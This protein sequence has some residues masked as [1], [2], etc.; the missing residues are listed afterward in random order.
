MILGVGEWE[1][2]EY[3]PPE[4]PEDPETKS[5][6]E[7]QIYKRRTNPYLLFL[8]PTL[9]LGVCLALTR[10]ARGTQ[11]TG[12]KHSIPRSRLAWAV[13]VLPAALYWAAHI[14]LQSWMDAP[15][16]PPPS[17]LTLAIRAVPIC[18]L[19]S[20]VEFFAAARRKDPLAVVLIAWSP[21]CS[22]AYVA[23]R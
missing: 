10:S 19:L 22:A 8:L 2:V 6:V 9:T 16:H 4:Q 14:Y 11:G 17:L 20:T 15:Y 18:L 7:A 3:S 1:L 23:F 13:I 21:F 5:F 12:A